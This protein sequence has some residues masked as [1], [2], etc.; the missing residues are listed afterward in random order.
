MKTTGPSFRLHLIWMLVL[1]ACLLVIQPGLSNPAFAG[2][3]TNPAIQLTSGEQLAHKVLTGSVA[4]WPKVQLWLTQ[5]SEIDDAP[6]VGRV[7]A[8][9]A[10]GA[11]VTYTLPLPDEGAS[12]FLMKV[13][14]VMFVNTGSGTGQDIVVIYSAAKIGPQR[15]P[16]FSTCVYHWNGAE[17]VRLPN[18]ERVLSG[19]RT[20]KQVAQRLANLKKKGGK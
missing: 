8:P 20:S 14:S 15:A 16:Y 12:S 10:A 9:N 6:F 7:V 4:H 1:A 17:F 3:P 18:V 2:E 13:L 19:A 5:S 11:E